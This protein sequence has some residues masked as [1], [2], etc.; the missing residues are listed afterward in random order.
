MKEEKLYLETLKEIKRVKE[1]LQRE[2]QDLE[3]SL[4]AW[5]EVS[6][7]KKMARQISE[8]QEVVAKLAG[9]PVGMLFTEYGSSVGKW[10]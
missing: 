7:F 3:D 6:E 5:H 8:L 9:E 2:I 10:E 4:I 1:D